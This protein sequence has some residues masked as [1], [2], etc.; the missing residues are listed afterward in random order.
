MSGSGRCMASP[1]AAWRI[2]WRRP[3]AASSRPSNVPAGLPPG[4]TGHRHSAGILRQ[5][6]REPNRPDLIFVCG[7]RRAVRR[8]HSP[9]NG[10]HRIRLP[11]SR[12]GAVPDRDWRHNA[13]RFSHRR[14]RTESPALRRRPGSLL[15]K[16]GYRLP[17][18][19]GEPPPK[20][21]RHSWGHFSGPTAWYRP[22]TGC[23]SPS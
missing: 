14:S 10:G 3:S 8:L 13:E 12:P 5:E 20:L 16:P 7:P 4:R 18:V 23:R 17:A 9:L 1:P 6:F 11:S 2:R 21:H 22:Q 19:L 15:A